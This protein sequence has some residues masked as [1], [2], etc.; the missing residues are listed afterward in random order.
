MYLAGVSVRRVEDISQALWGI[1]VSPSTVSNLNQQIY[2][3]IDELRNRPIEG[4]QAYVFL[5]GIVLKRTWADEVRN[6]SIL[7]AFGVNEDGFREM[8]GT[9][10]GPKEDKAGWGEFIRHFKDRGL[11]GVKLFVS[12]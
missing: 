12:V 8:L 2:A 7:L 5:D 6:V 11:K 10:E 1:K 9:W 3:K 4:E